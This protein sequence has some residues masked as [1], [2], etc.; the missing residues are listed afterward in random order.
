MAFTYDTTTDI[1]KIRLKIGDTVD[2]DGVK[3]AGGNFTDAEIQ[4]FLDEGG[5]ELAGSRVGM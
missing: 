5:G 4:V 1:G 2:G 3:P